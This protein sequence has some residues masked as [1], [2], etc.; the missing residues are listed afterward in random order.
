MQPRLPAHAHAPPDRGVRFFFYSN[1]GQ[2]PAHVH[3]RK[4]DGVA[5]VWL[6]PVRMAYSTGL[7]PTELRRVRELSVEHEVSFLE[8]WNEHFGR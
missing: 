1:E 8:L 3:V 4:A 2:E 5:K 6:E 7:N